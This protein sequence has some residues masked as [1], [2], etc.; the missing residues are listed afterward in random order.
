MM[1]TTYIQGS[2]KL[3]VNSDRWTVYPKQ[4]YPW[5]LHCGDVVALKI[6]GRYQSCRIE[7]GRDWYVIFQGA[8]FHLIRG[9][10]YDA[11]LVP[12]YF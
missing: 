1:K 3:D 6:G 5:D 7:M 8:S 2:M 11:R 4:G 10:T 12:I 9:K